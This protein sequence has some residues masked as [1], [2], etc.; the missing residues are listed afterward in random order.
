MITIR[1]SQHTASCDLSFQQNEKSTQKKYNHILN[2]IFILESTKELLQRKMGQL[3][4][5]IQR[6]KVQSLSVTR[7]HLHAAFYHWANLP[8]VRKFA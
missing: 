7:G 2:N 5:N 3:R 8:T 1:R 6:K 4:F